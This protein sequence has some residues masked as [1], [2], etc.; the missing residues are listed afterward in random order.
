M[1]GY[2]DITETVSDKQHVMINTN[3]R[4]RYL[5][6]GGHV[7]YVC[8]YLTNWADLVHLRCYLIWP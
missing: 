8:G 3:S 7:M 1:M 4:F 6:E 5:S 2:D